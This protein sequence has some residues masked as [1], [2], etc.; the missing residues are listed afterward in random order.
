MLTV[1]TKF[2]KKSGSSLL[3]NFFDSHQEKTIKSKDQPTSKPPLDDS[4]IT[5]QTLFVWV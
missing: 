5:Q 1:C 3:H 4:L 2:H